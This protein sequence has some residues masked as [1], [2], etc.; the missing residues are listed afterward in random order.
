MIAV[1]DEVRDAL[2]RGAGV[3]AL[4]TSVIAQG[5]PV[6]TN[7]EVARVLDRA[8]R[9]AGSV[10]GWVATDDG[11]VRVGLDAATL[12]RLA[13]PGGAVKVARR[14]IPLAVESGALGGT[15]VSATVWAA[16]A[17]GIA[18]S[19]TGG[20]GGVHPGSDDVSADLLELARTPGLL[21]CS[22][23]KSIVDPVATAERLE[24]LG[25][26]LVGY[27]VDRLPFFLVR[28]TSVELEHVVHDPVEAASVVGAARRLGARSTI[29]LCNPIP[30]AGGLDPRVV[31]EA[32]ERTLERAR[33]QRVHGKDLTP[34]LLSALAEET[35]GRSLRAN[36]ALLEAN[37]SLAGRIAEALSGL[38]RRG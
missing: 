14:D 9:E 23:P 38:E 13:E 18:V 10:P 19:A 4:E 31:E 21:V 12:D 16:A 26:A 7:R 32:V 6:P 36:V 37:A 22:G 5:L 25:V 24:E 27:G 1:S 29:L 2:A 33:T 28:E 30:E 15:T 11:A 17:A 34:F 3:V 35:D 8:V 20:I